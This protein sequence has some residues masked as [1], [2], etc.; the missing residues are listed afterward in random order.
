MPK[1]IRARAANNSNE[2]PT[3]NPAGHDTTF[4]FV[5]TLLD[6]ACRVSL[7]CSCLTTNKFRSSFV[8]RYTE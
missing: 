8:G 2:I 5:G 1:T 4:A 3:A 6:V 7:T